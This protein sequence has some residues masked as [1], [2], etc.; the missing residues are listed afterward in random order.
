[1]KLLLAGGADPNIA[2]DLGYTPLHEAAQYGH[3]EVRIPHTPMMM[4]T[5]RTRR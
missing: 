5:T 1:V 2:N 4:M 3:T